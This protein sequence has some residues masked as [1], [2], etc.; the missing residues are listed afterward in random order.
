MRNRRWY[1]FML[2]YGFLSFLL[3]FVLFPFMQMLSTSLKRPDE[4]FTIP[5]RWIPKHISF[6]NFAQALKYKQ[7]IGYFMNSLIVSIVTCILVIV[8]SVLA[9]YGFTR[10]EFRGRRFLLTMILFSQMFCISAIIIPLYKI[11]GSLGLLNSFPG[12]IIAYLAFTVP[13]AIW[14]LRGFLLHLPADMEEAA[15]IDGASQIQAFFRVVLPLLR[16][17][18]GATAAYVFF[19]TWQEFLFALVF[20]TEQKLRTLPVGI[21]DFKGQ[22]E[23][24]W[25]TMMAASVLISIPVFLL[26]TLIQRQLI[27]GLTEG[28]TKG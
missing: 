11:M 6:E 23:T 15:M 20:M 22:Y 8:I 18:I 4:L 28:A 7:F 26:F 12:L 5:P 17:G 14:L 2:L 13:V 25:G 10:L 19:L 3:F 16:P 27:A 24:N 9:T 21:M 1:D